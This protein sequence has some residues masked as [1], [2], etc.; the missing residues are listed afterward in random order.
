MAERKAAR[1]IARHRAPLGTSSI[2]AARGDKGSQPL[3]AEGS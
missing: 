3:P 1:A 2:I